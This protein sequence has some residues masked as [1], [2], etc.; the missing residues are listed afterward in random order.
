LLL[1]TQAFLWWMM[2]ARAL[3]RAARAAIAAPDNQVHFSIATAWEIAIK[4]DLGKLRL[5][6]DSAAAIESEAF[7]LLPIAPAHIKTLEKLPALHRDPFDRM[8]I[9]QANSESMRLVTCDREIARYDVD[10]LW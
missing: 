10:R 6:G 2:G 4:R 1:D 7:T 5:D 3:S 9:A 8:L